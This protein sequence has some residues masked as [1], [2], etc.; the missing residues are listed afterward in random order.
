[1]PRGPWREIERGYRSVDLHGMDRH[2]AG[3]AVRDALEACA[4]DGVKR[5]RIVHGKGTGALRDEVRFILEGS[6]HVADFRTARPRDG[7]DGAVEVWLEGGSRRGPV[8]G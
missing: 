2:G 8:R 5:L 6:A 3:L 4:R 7:G 1:M